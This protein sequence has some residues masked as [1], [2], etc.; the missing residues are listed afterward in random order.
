MPFQK[1][2]PPFAANRYNILFAHPGINRFSPCFVPE[3]A[4]HQGA[5]ADDMA[6]QRDYSSF[7]RDCM[8]I[9]PKFLVTVSAMLLVGLSQFASAQEVNSSKKHRVIIPPSS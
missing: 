1:I 6:L 3:R 8:R 2:S 9:V 7:R 4:S 5:V